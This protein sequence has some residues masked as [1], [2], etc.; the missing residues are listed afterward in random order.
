MAGRHA[1]KALARRR[2]KTEDDEYAAMLLRMIF[3][4]ADRIAADPTAGVHLKEFKAALTAA[5][6]LGFY[7]ANR[8]A[9]RPYGLNEMA[10]LTGISK[11]S[12]HEQI[13]RGELTR[14]A[15]EQAKAEGRPIVR[16]SDLRA[17]RLAVIEQRRSLTGPE[18]GEQDHD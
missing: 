6:N 3:K 8:Q 16:V 14:Q 9:D 18:R 15:L 17:A 11:Q 1:G 13:R 5:G 4:Y 10:E 7:G 12:L 2:R